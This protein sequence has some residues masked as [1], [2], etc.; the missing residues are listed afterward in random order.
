MAECDLPQEICWTLYSLFYCFPSNITKLPSPL[1]NNMAEC[2]LPQEICWTCIDKG[3]FVWRPTD[4]GTDST[5]Q[6]I[7]HKTP[8][9]NT[10][11]KLNQES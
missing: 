1:S 7:E 8:C 2:D 11:L 9:S 10:F 3:I 6:E 5:A 4:L